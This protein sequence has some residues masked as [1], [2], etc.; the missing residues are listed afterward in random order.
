MDHDTRLVAHPVG[1]GVR[2]SDL[3]AAEEWFHRALELD[4]KERASFLQQEVSD[5]GVRALAVELLAGHREDEDNFLQPTGTEE[6]G[7]REVAGFTLIRL[8]G[9]GGMGAVYEAKQSRP[10]RHVAL[11]LVRSLPG[12]PRDQRR[13]ELEAEVMARLRHPHVAQIYQV[14]HLE[15]EG[16]TW[17]AM[18]LVPQA[19]P[20]LQF[21]EEER[22]DRDARLH[23]ALDVAEAVQ[24]GHARGVIHRDLK[25]D[26]LLVDGEGRVKVIDFGIAQAAGMEGDG[27]R[28]PWMGTPAYMSP[29]QAGRYSDAIDARTDVYSLGVVLFELLAGSRPHAFDDLSTEEALKVRCETPAPPPSSFQPGIRADLDAVIL[30]ALALN[31]DE[32]YPTVEALAA[33][34]RRVL[35]SFPVEARPA[36]LLHQARLFTRRN[37]VASVAAGV[38]V[39]ALVSATVVS[40]LFAQDAID[41]RDEEASARERAEL[42][43]DAFE[44]LFTSARPTLH[45]DRDLTARELLL[46]AASHAESQLADQPEALADFL[47]TIGGSHATLG[48]ML[49]AEAILDR[50]AELADSVEGYAPSRRALIESRRG[51]VA[52][53]LGR[54]EEGIRLCEQAV[55][56]LESGSERGGVDHVVS[57]QRLAQALRLTPRAEEAADLLLEALELAEDAGPAAFQAHGLILT[58]LGDMAYEERDFD[59]T[60]ARHEEALAVF[61]ERLHRDHPLLLAPRIGMANAL[62]NQG[63]LDRAE[64]LWKE[65]QDVYARRI[66]DHPDRATVLVSLGHV[67]M[68]RRAFA[69]AEVQYREALAIRVDGFGAADYRVAAVHGHLSTMFTTQGALD[70]AEVEGLQAVAIQRQHLADN[71]LAPDL[72]LANQLDSVGVLRF[73]GSRWAEA[74]VLLNEAM[75]IRESLLPAA[76]AQMGTTLT[77]LGVVRLEQGDAAGAEDPLQKA[78]KLRSELL[79]DNWLTDNSASVLG[80][81]LAALGRIDEAEPLLLRGVHGL[82]K[83]LGPQD[84]RTK[85]AVNRALTAFENEGRAARTEEV[86]AALAAAGG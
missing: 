49:E 83:A 23:L 75:T 30:M 56:R 35:R 11:K 80:G 55:R 48:D 59:T 46:D 66:P 72:A 16:F 19:R 2:V 61:A 71:Q 36:S 78:Y 68:R 57:L 14:G 27:G 39:V 65:A 52:V 1:P 60:L 31:P 13:L 85:D 86:R 37:L 51:F 38:V 18:E 22:L 42:V 32:R 62:F 64:E 4:A 15:E 33:D 82:L 70:R 58:A 20:L 10:E 74:E 43:A 8:L 6:L 44:S 47:G 84:F 12:V 79:P 50:A 81:C 9:S 73:R 53:S 41:A 3:T 24:H 45:P 67:S 40:A 34:L 77:L 25:P 29:E 76:R 21:A 5:P 17:F 28:D 54:G 7:G 26:N 63:Q 69:D